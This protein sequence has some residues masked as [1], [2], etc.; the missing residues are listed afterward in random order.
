MAVLVNYRC[1]YCGYEV[2]GSKYGH[3]C[4]MTGEAFMFHCHSCHEIVSLI[5]EKEMIVQCPE[6]EETDEIYSWNPVDGRCPKCNGNMEEDR[7]S[8]IMC[9]D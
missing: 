7:S 5:S 6:C 4:V 2:Y 3:Y 1:Q 9:V 8:P